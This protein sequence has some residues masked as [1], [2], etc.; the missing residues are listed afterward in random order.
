MPGSVRVPVLSTQTTSVRAS[1]STA[2]ISCTS[3]CRRASRTTATAIAMLVRSTSP[4]GI[5]VIMPAMLPWMAISS[6]WSARSWLMTR[7]IPIGTMRNETTRMNLLIESRSSELESVNSL[8]AA[9]R[10]A[11]NE[12]APTLVATMTPDPAATKEPLMAPSPGTL[13]TASASP[14][15]RLSSSSRPRLA[16]TS[17]STTTWSPALRTTRSSRTIALTG[18][19]TSAPSRITVGRTSPIRLSLA[20]SRDA[21]YSWKMPMPVL[22]TM[23]RPNNACLGGATSIINTHRVPSNPLNHV[24]VLAF[25]MSVRLRLRAS[26]ALLASPAAT[27][28]AT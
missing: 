5:I 14:V 27:R 4:S 10:P 26:G 21:R 12:S 17:P 16:V 20:S 1:A 28:A 22:N 11:A 7:R 8:A 24:N 15:S 9:V 19:W 2:G 13:S 6:G 23:T 3:A 18:T 25:T